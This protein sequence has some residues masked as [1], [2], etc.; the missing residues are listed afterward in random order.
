[1]TRS[2]EFEREGYA[3]WRGGPDVA[4]IGRLERE[5]VR[6]Y[7]GPLLRQSMRMARNGEIDPNSFVE[8]SGIMDP[9]LWRLPMLRSFSDEMLRFL[10]SRP[11][12]DA[13]HAIDGEERY[14][15]H[16]SIFFFVSPRL[17]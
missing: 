9:H 16:Q 2:S 17:P 15:L 8:R 13:L 11:V 7:P 1:M 14:T 10:T 4:E 5:V 3:I 12:F 6:P